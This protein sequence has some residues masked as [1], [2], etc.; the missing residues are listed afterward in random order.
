MSVK[1]V[2]KLIDH[3][4]KSSLVEAINL[5]TSL[6]ER[7]IEEKK[8]G[9][10]GDVRIRDALITLPK[11][12][13]IAVVGDIHGDIHSLKYI[14]TKIVEMEILENGYL[15]FLGDYV[16]RGPYSIEVLLSLAMLKESNN[17]RVFL[18]RGNHEPPPD[19]LPYPHDLPYQVMRKYGTEGKR[20]YECM[21]KLF[22]EL[23]VA[24]IVEERVFMVHGGI[25]VNFNS[26]DDFARAVKLHPKTTYLEEILWNDPTEYLETW[27]PSPRGAGRIFGIKITQKALEILKVKAIIRGHEPCPNGYKF[28][29]KGLVLTLF[30]RKGAPYFNEKAAFL[31]I[32]TKEFTEDNVRNVL[33]RGIV[34][35]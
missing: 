29:H 9:R 6:R 4:Y 3:A 11:D 24:A 21:M 10:S 8:E 14:L 30:S 22:N 28:N 27:A 1:D 34:I 13:T 35:F 33:E 25:P 12:S 16:D 7:I 31:I 5:I 26:I 2:E 23:Y 18:L 19:L 32:D 20:L 15:V 17:E